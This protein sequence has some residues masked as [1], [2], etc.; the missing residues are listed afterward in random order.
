MSKVRTHREWFR[1]VARGG[2]KSCTACGARLADDESI[3]SWG[4]YHNARWHSVADFC[5]E[6]FENVRRRLVDHAGGCG[7]QFELVGKGCKLPPWLALG[8]AAAPGV[9]T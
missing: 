5:K 2:R 6:C 7:C 9:T 8:G 1:P 3:W 4:E